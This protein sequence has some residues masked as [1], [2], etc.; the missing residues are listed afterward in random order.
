[1][2]KIIFYLLLLNSLV[3]K[4]GLAK[5]FTTEDFVYEEG[6][7]TPLLFPFTG[8][9]NPKQVDMLN[10]PIVSMSQESPL[11]LQFDEMGGDI[12]I[13]YVKIINC[14]ADWSVSQLNAIQYLNEYNEYQIT[15]REASFNTRTPY[16]HYRF[17]L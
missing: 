16:I 1:M 14:N 9:T 12:K 17:I 6:I 7:K 11:M 13:Y 5:E 2:K 8:S 15:E 10:P 3:A 4:S